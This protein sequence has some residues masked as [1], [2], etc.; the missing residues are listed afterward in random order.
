[1]ITLGVGAISVILAMWILMLSAAYRMGCKHKMREWRKYMDCMRANLK[2]EVARVPQS[3]ELAYRVWYL[4]AADGETLIERQP[5]VWRPLG[6]LGF[7]SNMEFHLKMDPKP[8]T[9]ENS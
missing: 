7:D 4:I 1:M 9:H 6:E 8:T 2:V 3:N 5:S